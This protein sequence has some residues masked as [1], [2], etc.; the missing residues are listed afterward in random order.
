MWLD[1]SVPVI[2]DFRG[3]DESQPSDA[4]RDALWCLLPGRA[5]GSAWVVGMLR[6]QFVEVAPSCPQL[7]V[8]QDI[9]ALMTDI[10][11]AD[12]RR[13]RQFAGMPGVRG[14][15]RRYARF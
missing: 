8:V 9:V 14:P 10:R 15:R 6:K 5:G 13:T 12:A 1:S 2:F 7:P 3:V 4:H 11:A